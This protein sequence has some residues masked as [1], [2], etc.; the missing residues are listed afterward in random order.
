MSNKK[1]VV[2]KE[3]RKGK[4][5]NWKKKWIIL[6]RFDVGIEE[7]YQP[8]A[9]GPVYLHYMPDGCSFKG[10]TMH[11]R[12]S[13]DFRM[14]EQVFMEAE[15]KLQVQS[16]RILGHPLKTKRNVIVLDSLETGSLSIYEPIEESTL[17]IV[18]SSDGCNIDGANLIGR[19]GINILPEEKTV[20]IDALHCKYGYED[21]ANPMIEQVQY[22]VDFYEEF[23]NLEFADL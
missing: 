22:F 5:M 23:D 15:E 13:S 10:A 19:I 20:V 2:K 9:D 4:V 14:A 8:D 6:I 18:H 1:N 11:R 12:A 3:E 7:E 21:L 17:S 16:K